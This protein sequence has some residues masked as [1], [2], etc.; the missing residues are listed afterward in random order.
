MFILKISTLC[1]RFYCTT[2]LIMAIV[3]P[4]YWCAVLYEWRCLSKGNTVR[5]WLVLCQ[6]TTRWSLVWMFWC[7]VKFAC[8]PHAFVGFLFLWF[9][10]KQT[11][12]ILTSDGIKRAALKNNE[13]VVSSGHEVT[14]WTD[15]RLG[16]SGPVLSFCYTFTVWYITLYLCMMCDFGI[17]L[18]II[19][20]N[21]HRKLV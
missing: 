8:S 18:W 20:I 14:S 12:H 10:E 9:P 11:K 7:H 1:F 17:S 4:T 2:V 5:E 19:E 6:F 16:Y 13:W 21:V 15:V 3:P